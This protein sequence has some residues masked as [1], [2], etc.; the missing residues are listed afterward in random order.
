MRR[1]TGLVQQLVK[2][3][4][5]PINVRKRDLSHKRDHGRIHA[6]GGQQGSARVQET[7]PWDHRADLRPA[8][9]QCCPECHIGGGLLVSRVD[10][11]E[12][13]TRS[14]KGVEERVALE[15]GEGVDGI[16]PVTQQ[17][18]HDGVRGSHGW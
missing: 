9:G 17:C 5:P 7:G 1:E 15:A 12:A 3:T 6:L 8:G 10:Y 18:V 2:V 14:M 13:M 11:P 4:V 16:D